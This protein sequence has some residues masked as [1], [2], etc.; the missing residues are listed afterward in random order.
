MQSMIRFKESWMITSTIFKYLTHFSVSTKGIVSKMFSAPKVL[1]HRA[2]VAHPKFAT[3]AAAPQVE[4]SARHSKVH[5]FQ[6]DKRPIILFDGVCNFCNNGVDFL[7]KWDTQR[8]FRVGALQS[9]TGRALLE[10]C[11]RKS[12]DISSMVVVESNDFHIK[13]DAALEIAKRLQL[14]LPLVSTLITPVPRPLRDAMYDLVA[15]NRYN[16]MGTRDVCRMPTKE[17]ADRFV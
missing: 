1:R 2:I 8:V 9:E 15:D 5:F 4:S 3:L 12:D 7:L 6:Q 13:S 17:D 16:F 14:P 10:A 11:G